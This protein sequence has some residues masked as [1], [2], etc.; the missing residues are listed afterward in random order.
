MSQLLVKILHSDKKMD[1]VIYNMVHFFLF[2]LL[3]FLPFLSFCNKTHKQPDI[4][5]RKS[6]YMPQTS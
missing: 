4:L 5:C 1:H 2:F 6:D 3:G